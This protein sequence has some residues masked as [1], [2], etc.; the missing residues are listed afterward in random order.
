MAVTSSHSAPGN[1]L[2]FLAEAKQQSERCPARRIY[3]HCGIRVSTEI[4]RFRGVLGELIGFLYLN[5]YFEQVF[6][7]TDVCMQLD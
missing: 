4:K 2:G 3:L 5:L 1:F 7:N 6:R